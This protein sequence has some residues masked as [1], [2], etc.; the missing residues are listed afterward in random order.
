M[1]MIESSTRYYSLPLFI[2][3]VVWEIEEDHKRERIFKEA[4]PLQH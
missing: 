2:M 1:R 4:N 3:L